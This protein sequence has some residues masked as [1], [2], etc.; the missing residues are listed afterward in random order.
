MPQGDRQLSMTRLI[1][2]AA[3]DDT[4]WP[5]V[6]ERL[7]DE[8]GGS[9]AGFHYRLGSQGVIRSARFVGVD[10]TL[11]ASILTYY[12]TRNPWVRATQPLFRPGD[13]IATDD[14]VSPS[15][16]RRT[17]YYDGILKPLGLQH[18]V[19][20]CVFKRGEDLL[21]FTAVRSAAAG[22]YQGDELRRVRVI[23]PHLHRALRVNERL[24]QLERTR[25]ALAD[26]MDTLKD[27]VIVANRAGRVVFA[28]RAARAIVAQRDGLSIAPDGLLASVH[29][30]RFK[31]RAL[32][33]DAALSSAGQG[34]GSGGTM[35]VSRPSLKR[36]FLVMVAPL[37]LPLDADDR[38]GHIAVFVSDPEAPPETMDEVAERLYGLTAS[39][40]RVAS[41]LMATGDLGQVAE[42]LRISRETARW[43]LKRLYRKTGTNRQAGLVVRLSRIRSRFTL[44]S[45][46]DQHAGQESMRE[47]A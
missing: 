7:A 13:V 19:G 44:Y 38:T 40:T 1:Y 14:V 20:A 10:P 25:A 18:G 11:G 17:E 21:T 5:T 15:S 47:P 33:N 30:D 46:P 42:Q 24:S 35:T 27:G 32:L 45:R 29:S 12:S 43:H 6:L 4:R 2:T 8:Y 41:G 22:P 23:L 36:P 26:S 3:A 37:A 31:L 34:F 16:L 9:V 28:N 39:E